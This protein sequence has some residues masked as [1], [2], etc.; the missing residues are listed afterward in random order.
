MKY[1]VYYEYPGMPK[2]VVLST[3]AEAENESQARMEAVLV[4]GL[5]K[6]IT[7]VEKLASK[8]EET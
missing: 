6:K 8:E 4:L 1:K 3:T 2:D 7:K 5:N